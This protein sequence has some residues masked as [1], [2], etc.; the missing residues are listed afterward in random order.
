MAS[1]CPQH[2][3]GSFEFFP[4]LRRPLSL[5]LTFPSDASVWNSSTVSL[6]SSY[7]CTMR[8]HHTHSSQLPL[9]SESTSFL[10][11]PVPPRPSGHLTFHPQ[12]LPA[13]WSSFSS[14]SWFT[15]MEV[16][17]SDRTLL[18]YPEEPGHPFCHFPYAWSCALTSWPS[19]LVSVSVLNVSLFASPYTPYWLCIF[20]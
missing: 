4:R 10:T 11:A 17:S 14:S 1:H 13:G 19:N 7:T 20:P 3:H 6:R 5:G 18:S 15:V 9:N 12:R 16:I 2:L 8:C